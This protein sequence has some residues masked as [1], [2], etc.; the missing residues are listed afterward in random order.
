MAACLRQVLAYVKVRFL[1][2]PQPSPLSTTL[3][4]YSA[5]FDLFDDFPGYVNF[6]LLRDIVTADFSAVT[7]FLPFQSFDDDPVPSTL[8][9]YRSYKR[10]A[11]AFIEARNRRIVAAVA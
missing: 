10:L 9:S 3:A 2:S 8:E 11:M 5:F 6:F 7:Y 1:R 4:R